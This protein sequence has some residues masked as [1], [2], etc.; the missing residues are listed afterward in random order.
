LFVFLLE[1]IDPISVRLE[2]KARFL[3][4]QVT[5]ASEDREE[6]KTDNEHN[7]EDVVDLSSVGGPSP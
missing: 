4:F 5:A 1:C 2:F 6:R 7:T 3:E